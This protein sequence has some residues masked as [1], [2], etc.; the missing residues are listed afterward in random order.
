MV[1][2]TSTGS[3][4]L[5]TTAMAALALGVVAIAPTTG[6]ADAPSVA[7]EH[8]QP[9]SAGTTGPDCGEASEDPSFDNE[10]WDSIAVDPLDPDNMIVAWSEADAINCSVDGAWTSDGGQTWGQVRI[11]PPAYADPWLSFGL[12]ADGTPI[13]YLSASRIAADNFPVVTTSVDGG[14]TWSEPVAVSS[15]PP[16]DPAVVAHPTVPCRAYVPISRLYLGIWL[17]ETDDCGETWREQLVMLPGID[18][19]L[20]ARLIIQPTGALIIVAPTVSNTGFH[21]EFVHWQTSID[22]GSSP[23]RVIAT[24]STDDGETWSDP[25]TIGEAARFM[26]PMPDGGIRRGDLQPTVDLGPA[27]TVYVAWSDKRSPGSI[28]MT[29]SK[30]AGLT[31]SE[32]EA[33]ASSS[34]LM[35]NPSLAVMD[36]GTI[37]VNYLDFRNDTP[38]TDVM[39]AD[40]WFSYRAPGAEHWQEV[41]VAG[42]TDWDT[43]DSLDNF[44]YND[45]DALP[46][47]FAAVFVLREPQAQAGP[48]DVFFARIRIED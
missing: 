46:D 15:L 20:G 30:D 13:A 40:A 4:T 16:D 48:T 39:S 19:V 43:G 2:W 33:I 18:V 10:T 41:H 8:L 1:R 26:S 42:P 5:F 32:P 9:L 14:K 24:R 28:V 22:V 23:A 12:A 25:V 36:D 38:S 3:R 44:Q 47:G 7:I 21:R 6:I 37:G 17:A 34:A 11:L 29:T 31:W 35:F 27:D 45:M